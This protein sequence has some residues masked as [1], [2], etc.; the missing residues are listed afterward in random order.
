[1][2]TTIIYTILLVLSLGAKG[3]RSMTL[4]ECRQQAIAYNKEL[5]KAGLQK[6]EAKAYQKAARTAYLPAISADASAMYMPGMDDI[7]IPGGFL[8]TAESVEA[9]EA[10]QF[11]GVSNVYNP[12]MSLDMDDLSIIN[13]GINVVQPI[14]AGGQI[15]NTNKK[16]DAGFAITEF[17]HSLKYSEVIEQTDVAFWN[18]AM[19]AANIDLAEKYI[20]MLTEL[21]EQMNDMHEVGLAP[22]SEKLR[23]SVQKNEAELNLMKAR[24]GLK[25]SKMYL[26]QVIGLDLNSDIQIDYEIDMNVQLLDLS[27]GVEMAMDNRKELQILEKQV[28]MSVIEKKLALS[29]YL[30]QLGVSAGYSTYHIDNFSNDVKFNP[31]VGAQLTIPIFQWGQGKQKQKAA[32]FKIQQNET[33]LSNT[34]DLISLEVLKVKVQVEEAYEEIRIAQKNIKEAEESL[35][36]TKASFEVGLN[37][38]TELL[39]AQADWQNANAQLITSMAKF[40]VLQ[41]SW[42][43]VTGSL[44]PMQ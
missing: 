22:I 19:V 9:A 43:K 14:Y 17:N 2:K 33:A 39:N 10:G 30:P 26:N 4:E 40:K 7:S 42:E 12:G 27:N 11:S 38:T 1:M 23:V 37:T 20:E 21:E 34:S 25:V 13:G 16:A 6:E 24:N 8:P 31:T 41:T 29:E 15:I 18:V 5:K 3:Q 44:E 35:E 28:E 32:S 36:E